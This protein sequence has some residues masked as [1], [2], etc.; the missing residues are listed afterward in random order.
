[1]E[2]VDVLQF[3]AQPRTHNPTKIQKER[4]NG[5]SFAGSYY[6]LR[7][8]RS[9]DMNRLFRAS[10]PYNLYIYDRNYE[11]TKIGEKMNFL[12]PEEFREYILGSLPFYQIDKA[13]KGYKYMININTVKTS[14]TMYARRVYEGLAS[15]TPI[16]SN[17]SL[18]MINQFGDLIGASES[19]EELI[20]YLEN[21]ENNPDQ[22]NKVKQLGIRRVL[23]EHTYE[24]RLLQIANTLEFDIEKKEKTVQIVSFIEDLKD[25]EIVF[26]HFQQIDYMNKKLLIVSNKDINDY[27]D[28]ESKVMVVSKSNIINLYSTLTNFVDSQFILPINKDAYYGMNYV[29]D[30]LLPSLYTNASI[31]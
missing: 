1:H 5:I 30:L 11:F 28:I 18:G 13:Y 7:E 8:E 6:A 24:H 15:G 31:I 17:Y 4:V 22:Y 19:E 3:A 9:N 14:P 2:N 20:A 29:A 10:I 23:S 16:I 27:S 25:I 26:N 12:F 21:L